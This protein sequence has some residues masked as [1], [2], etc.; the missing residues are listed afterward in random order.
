M[1]LIGFN[2]THMDFEKKSDDLKDLKINVNTNILDLK[3][4]H[5]DVFN[6]PEKMVAVKFDYSIEYTKDIALLKFEGTMILSLD[7]KL[8]KEVVESWKDKKVPEGFRLTVF[9]IILK[10]AGIKAL[11]V[12]EEFNLPP[13]LPFPSFKPKEN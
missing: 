2:I 3:E 8:S 13:H 9:N 1:R 12:E 11:Q 7:E 4:V 10:K 5:S 6:S